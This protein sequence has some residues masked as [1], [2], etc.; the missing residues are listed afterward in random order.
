MFIHYKKR[1]KSNNISIILGL[2]LLCLLTGC[3]AG[4]T[5]NET[6]GNQI[7]LTPTTKPSKDGSGLTVTEAE[8]ATLA[9]EDTDN[10][11]N[12]T[13]DPNLKDF[14]ELDEYFKEYTFE[15]LYDE[16]LETYQRTYNI[17]GKYDL[18]GDGKADKIDGILDAAY[19]DDSYI[20]IN[21]IK[22]ILTLSNP[23]G[24]MQL[25]DL[26]SKDSYIE[27]AIFDGGPSGDPSYVLYRYDGIKLNYLGTIDR[28]AM[29]DGRGKF[30][31]WFHLANNFKPQ[32]Y[33][34]WNEIKNNEIVT[35][36]HEVEQ[37]IGNTYE[38][39]GTGFFVP[40]DKNPK[41]Y[42]EHTVWELDA[43]REFKATKIKILDI[44]INQT[45]RTLN[46]FYV[47][48]PQGERGLLY[49]WIGD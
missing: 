45:D 31:S 32:F 27:L 40:L 21:G 22:V 18:N 4:K 6:N 10:D 19:E 5:I 16:K 48:L 20:E 17:H 33:S 47:E 37:Y 25:I 24:E 36:N 35:T 29:A 8:P 26:D 15:V 28:Y 13:K 14:T 38:V 30:I 12:V 9:V 7:A 42:F 49:F 39:N 46:W 43:Q 3:E 1:K 23:S 41:D 44:H 11:S 2:F 34:A